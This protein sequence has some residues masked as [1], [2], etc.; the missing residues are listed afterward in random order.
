MAR[1]IR[2]QQQVHVL[3]PLSLL[4][5]LPPRRT[6]SDE[7]LYDRGR[8]VAQLDSRMRKKFLIGRTVIFRQV[9][10]HAEFF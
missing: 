8:G 5:L 4:L 6:S 3:P 10:A 1:L 2:A 7:A 9:P